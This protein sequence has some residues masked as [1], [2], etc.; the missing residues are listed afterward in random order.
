MAEF[1]FKEKKK[2]NRTEIPAQ[3]KERTEQNTGVSFSNVRTQYNSN[4]LAK[5]GALAYTQGTPAEVGLGQNQHMTHKLDHVVQQKLE[6]VRANAMH[7][8]GVAMNTDA[9]LERQANEIGAGRRIDI[10]TGQG[11]KV[12]QLCDSDKSPDWEPPTGDSYSEEEETEQNSFSKINW[13]GYPN[14]VPKPT[15]FFVILE[16]GAYVDARRRANQANAALH[17]EH[18]E[19]AG[20]EIHEVHPVKFG[21][22]PEDVSNKVALTPEIH[23]QCTNFWNNLLRQLKGI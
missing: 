6:L 3:P 18:P 13:K 15:G 12:V 10:G 20:L 8:G 9:G 1:A 22:D 2:V 17:G 19:W 16:G 23:R 5:L 4:K 14:S 7:P 21:G 11:N